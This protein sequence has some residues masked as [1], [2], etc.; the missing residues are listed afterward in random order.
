MKKIFSI[1]VAALFCASMW[2]DELP[3]V[4]LAGAFTNWGDDAITLVDNGDGTASTEVHF[5][6]AGYYLFKMIVDGTWVV[7]DGD[8]NY[9]V[10]RD[11]YSVTNVTN[12]RSDNFELVADAAGDYTFKWTYDGSNLDV[13]FPDE[14][15]INLTDGY[16]LVGINGWLIANV[17][18]NQK[19][20]LTEDQTTRPGQYVL[21]NVVLALN[22]E[23]KVVEVVNNN[24]KEGGTW[25]GSGDGNNNFKVT[26][27][28]VGT[29]DIYFN[30]T[31][32]DDW[33]GYV[34]VSTNSTTAIDNTAVEG[35]AVKVIRDGQVLIVRDGKTYN[36]LGAE[37]K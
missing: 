19:F 16:Y 12:T 11:S 27:S 7:A 29:K 14:A 20:E 30:P 8:G 15:V 33:N 9:Q 31:W 34:Y 25:Y 2:A 28:Y 18:A 23:F 37:V 10:T 35:K 3:V 13:I 1:F 24:F 4:K 32:Q 5:D 26:E 17:D 36:A 21:E 22:N 6:A